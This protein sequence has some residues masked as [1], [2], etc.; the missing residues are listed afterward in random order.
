MKKKKKDLVKSTPVLLHP[1][2]TDTFNQCMK[3]PQYSSN[4]WFK[5]LSVLKKTNLKLTAHQKTMKL[6]VNEFIIELKTTKF[7]THENK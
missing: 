2:I 4:V 7:L 6:N 1:V 3:R 5:L